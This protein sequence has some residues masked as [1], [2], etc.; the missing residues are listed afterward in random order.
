MSDRWVVDGS[1]GWLNARAMHVNWTEEAESAHYGGP[2]AHYDR[3]PLP[4]QLR[5]MLNPHIGLPL[6]PFTIWTHPDPDP[7]NL[8]KQELANL[9][10]WTETEIVGLPVDGNLA[11]TPYSGQGQGPVNAPLSPLDAALRRLQV[12]APRIGWSR[13]FVGGVQ[14]P[15]WQAPDAEK[16]LH[17]VLSSRMMQGIAQMLSNTQSASEHYGFSDSEGPQGA[18][19]LMPHLIIDDSA[20]FADDPTASSSEWYPLH[21]LALTAGSDPYAALALGFGTA[22][23]APDRHQGTMLMVSVRHR[24]RPD[25]SEIEIADIM[26][27]FRPLQPPRPASG[28][29]AKLISHTPPQKLDGP[30]LDSIGVS[31][32]RPPNPAYAVADSDE[33]YPA[34]YAVANFGPVPGQADI[35]LTPRPE[36]I[37]GWMPFVVSQVADARPILFPHHLPRVTPVGRP[38]VLSGSIIYAVAAQDLFGRW[39][40]WRT[41]QFSTPAE[42]PQI[43]RIVSVTVGA[44]GDVQIDFAWDWSDRSPQFIELMGIYA[45]D[46][47]TAVIAGRLDFTSTG[48]PAS[49]PGITGLDQGMQGPDVWG[50]AQDVPGSAPGWRYYRLKGSVA[51]NFA[52]AP[53]RD[54]EVRA[55]GQCR[56]HHDFSGGTYNISP[57]GPPAVT[58]VFD[59]KPP[60]RPGLPE[61]PQWASLPDATGV[62]RALLN[63]Q[64]VERAKGYVV[65]EATET[66]I[67][68]ALGSAGPDTATAF[69]SRLAALRAANL[70][71][72]R[73]AFRRVTPDIILPGN[74][75][76]AF[77][78]EL[79]RGS[80]VIHLFAVT[81][82]GENEQ[83]SEWPKLSKDFAAFATPRLK[84]PMPPALA[85]TLDAGAVPSAVTLTVEADDAAQG[86]SVEIFRTVGG[87]IAP[88]IDAMG[89]PLITRTMSASPLSIP[90]DQVP[91]GWNRLWYRA[92]V[93]SARDDQDGWVE[94]RSSASSPVA[95]MIY[96]ATGPS[97]SDIRVNE[98]GS[99]LDYS[100][101]SFATSAPAQLTPLGSH[102]AVIEARRLDGS[103]YLRVLG[104]IDTLDQVASVLDLPPPQ[105]GNLRI[106]RVNQG[107]LYRL[108]AWLPWLAVGVS[109]RVE[110]KVIDPLGR[111]GSSSTDVSAPPPP[112]PEISAISPTSAY[113]GD[114]F[115]ITGRNFIVPPGG[116]LSVSIRFP[117]FPSSEGVTVISGSASEIVALVPDRVGSFPIAVT[118]SD[119]AEAVSAMEFNVL[120]PTI[121]FPPGS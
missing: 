12:G 78:A 32:D 112:D 49:H 27:P 118:R 26:W 82:I 104:L 96:P 111:I 8:S 56:L 2:L 16:Y 21:L 108:Y 17:F 81:A 120:D 114:I 68:S 63:W 117:D 97:V 39:S 64:N 59:P 18:T 13:I 57:F 75:G 60:A 22:V 115:K 45:D 42:P 101:V 119:G 100:L 95:L 47:G 103:S 105:P 52:A 121:L 62:S 44:A 19:S 35:L 61:A 70:P 89:P 102:Q 85:V 46:P 106:I 4:V 80:R 109:F 9:P 77:E 88:A 37:G 113:P 31:W 30:T 53:W 98:L 43:P 3:E 99:T 11:A 83:E 116:S 24:L 73:H 55:R 71:G 51:T 29:A 38:D 94:A 67:L 87:K 33:P 36:D 110:M 6:Q 48:E 25:T 23:Y 50:A 5:W 1:T 28:L 86:G 93:W 91:P 107:S 7:G 34:S 69:T 90:D 10:G 66:A 76:T 92:Q 65:Y 41:V 14:M 15:D 84:T 58:R 72:F 20:A 74:G 40:A 54:L 79:P